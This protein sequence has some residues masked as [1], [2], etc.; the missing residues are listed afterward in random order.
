MSLFSAG[1]SFHYAMCVSVSFFNTAAGSN[2][3]LVA[4]Q[5]LPIDL[6]WEQPVLSVSFVPQS[7]MTHLAADSWLTVCTIILQSFSLLGLR[8]N[9]SEIVFFKSVVVTACCVRDSTG[10]STLT[11]SPK[12]GTRCLGTDLTDIWKYVRLW[13]S[14]QSERI[15]VGASKTGL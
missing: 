9:R 11:V 15:R 3:D 8:G 13:L 6:P 2:P 14:G 4:V 5:W 1:F 7:D 12:A 10:P